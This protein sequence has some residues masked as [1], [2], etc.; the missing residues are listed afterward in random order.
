MKNNLQNRRKKESHYTDFF[1]LRFVFES[2]ISN[3]DSLS[4]VPLVGIREVSSIKNK[5]KISH[6]LRKVG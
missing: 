5:G 6:L 4:E 2:G 3:E 1:N